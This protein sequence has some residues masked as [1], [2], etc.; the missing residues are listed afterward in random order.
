MTTQSI[1]Q[2]S[3]GDDFWFDD[4]NV[5]GCC[6]CNCGKILWPKNGIYHPQELATFNPGFVDF[7]DQIFNLGPNF[8]ELPGSLRKNLHIVWLYSSTGSYTQKRIIGYKLELAK[9]F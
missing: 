8:W 5:D 9:V 1:V 4:F 2:C 6:Q 3:V 7:P